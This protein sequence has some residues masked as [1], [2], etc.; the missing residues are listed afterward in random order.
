MIPLPKPRGFWDYELFALMLTG[1]LVLLF[2]VEASNGVGWADAALAFGAAELCVLTIVFS[3]RNEKA[4]WIVRSSWQAN[5]LVTLG[6]VL[7][8]FAV[9]YADA[10]ILHRKD[11]T[12]ARIRHDMILAIA[13]PI[14]M[15]LP[16]RRRHT[17]SR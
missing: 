17:G 3:R 4:A 12:T 14:A 8:M 16:L 11:M 10:Y 1:L 15:L 13:L 2:W 6:S 7:L 9:L 5:P